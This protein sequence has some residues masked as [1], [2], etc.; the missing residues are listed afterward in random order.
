MK[1]VRI[2]L[3]YGGSGDILHTTLALIVVSTVVSTY[4]SK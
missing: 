2:A 4:K 3:L 1:T